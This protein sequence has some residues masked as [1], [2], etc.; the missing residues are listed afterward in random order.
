M[1]QEKQLTTKD[2]IN[3]FYTKL[4][5]ALKE[6]YLNTEDLDWSGIQSHTMK[7]VL[8]SKTLN[9]NPVVVLVLWISALLDI[10]GGSDSWKKEKKKKRLL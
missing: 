10:P 2:S 6:N 1:S 4:F 7:E 8:K 9:E 5:E 3:T